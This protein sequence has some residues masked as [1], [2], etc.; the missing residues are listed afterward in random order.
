M[1]NAKPPKSDDASTPREAGDDAV[2]HPHETHENDPL[3]SAITRL[4]RDERTRAREAF[5]PRLEALAEGM[6]T[7]DEAG[8]LATELSAMPDMAAIHSAF[9][10]M[11][12]AARAR[13]TA[14]ILR[15]FK[16]SQPVLVPAP[17]PASAP[18]VLAR[19]R[20]GRAVALIAPLAVA[21]GL[22]LTFASL[23][24]AGSIPNYELT[25]SGEQP[26]RGETD[27]PAEPMG[28]HRFS[29]H[30]RFRVL[31][32][33]ER[34]FEGPVAARVFLVRGGD[35]R[36][37]HTPVDVSNEGAIRIVTPLETLPA[38]SGG[39]WDMVIVVGRPDALPDAP[40]ASGAQGTRAMH[41]LRARVVFEGL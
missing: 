29:P 34:A 41:V 20:I 23:R 17:I 39:A 25:L 24:S 3:L 31:L 6:L 21:A 12:D 10:P 35:V 5:A 19:R 4:A 26:M 38:D 36:I 9:V 8:A 30:E 16:P 1:T 15:N 40:P 18:P 33:P 22:L 11:D 37:W 14:L 2:A 13:T 28:T 32:R 27:S 7:Q